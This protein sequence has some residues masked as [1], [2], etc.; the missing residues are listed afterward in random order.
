MARQARP[1]KA[2]P[3]VWRVALEDFWTGFLEPSRVAALTLLLAF[4]CAVAG[5]FW[6]FSPATL[7][8]PLGAYL[9]RSSLDAEGFATREALRLAARPQERPRLIILGPSTV[10]QAFGA[11]AAVAPHLEEA[12]GAP[13]GVHV[14]T[15]PLQSPF[16]QLAL[17]E[18][19]LA[20]RRPG[21]PPVV[22]AV[23]IGLQRLG[24]TPARLIDLERQGRI[25]LRSDWTDAEMARLGAEPRP[26][27]G[28][29]LFDNH[30]FVMINATEAL[31]RLALHRAATPKVDV[32]SRGATVPVG[33]RHRT[34]IAAQIR[35]GQDNAEAYYALHARLAARLAG[36]PG[37]RLVFVEEALSPEFI[38]AEDLGDMETAS[39]AEF[40]EFARSVGAEYW[41]VMTE[42]DLGPEDYHDD[43]HIEAGPAQDRVR[44]AFAR[45]F[46]PLAAQL[47]E[48]TP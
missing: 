2:P 42:A 15:T 37:V 46:A 47:E 23:D 4:A 41:P 35:G 12:A 9:P 20:G 10:A 31:T 32:Y 29:Y 28:V 14:L 25:G 39:R 38:A 3:P 45:H 1:A 13:W 21:D 36:L 18:T 26:R 27:T 7:A 34:Q 6:Y 17:I 24:W 11:G 5:A 30:R 44:A 16:D 40:A 43:L 22:V 48:E 19:A 33:E 8:G